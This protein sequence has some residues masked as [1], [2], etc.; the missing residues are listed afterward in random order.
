MTSH[1]IYSLLF[2]NYSIILLLKFLIK[3]SDGVKI[4]GYY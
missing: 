2:E 4:H 3:K 1:L